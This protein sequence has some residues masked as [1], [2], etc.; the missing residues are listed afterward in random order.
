MGGALSFISGLLFTHHG[1]NMGKLGLALI[2]I[3]FDIIFTVQ[4]FFIYPASKRPKIEDKFHEM[5]EIDC[6]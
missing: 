4:H 1:L 5:N 6:P 3:V 2:S